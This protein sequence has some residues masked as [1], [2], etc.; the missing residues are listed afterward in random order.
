MY[1]AIDNPM[2]VRI[3]QRALRLHAGTVEFS[4]ALPDPHGT[5][6]TVNGDRHVSEFSIEIGLAEA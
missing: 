5:S 1:L 4:E 6:F 3:F 2:T